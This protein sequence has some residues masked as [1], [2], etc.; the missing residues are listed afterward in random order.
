VLTGKLKVLMR[1]SQTLDI[2][3]QQWLKSRDMIPFGRGV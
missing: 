2:F 3:V 1:C